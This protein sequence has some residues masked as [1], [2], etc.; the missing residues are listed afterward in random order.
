MSY[1]RELIHVS[2]IQLDVS[3]YAAYSRI[4]ARRFLHGFARFCREHAV[5]K[6][7]DR[8]HSCAVGQFCARE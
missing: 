4:C 2:F 7:V 5:G 8:A 1:V 3:H 6:T